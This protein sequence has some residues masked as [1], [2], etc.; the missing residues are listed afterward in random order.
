MDKNK[1]GD[2]FADWYEEELAEKY[3]EYN[4]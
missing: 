1:K 4:K 3:R 2:C